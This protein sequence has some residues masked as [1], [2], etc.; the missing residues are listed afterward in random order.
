MSASAPRRT[1]DVIDRRVGVLFGVFVLLLL[2]A[3][4]RSGYLGLFRGSALRQA[5]NDQQVQTTP[6]PAVRGEITDRD[7]VVLALSEPADEII[8][9]PLLIDR[10]YKDPQA[11]AAQLA[12]LLGMTKVAAIAGMTKPGTGYVKLS[13]NVSA[14]D[15]TKIMALN[16][17]GISEVPTE[18]QAYPRGTEA[19]Q[20]IGWTGSGGGEG[21]EY[22]FN[23]QLEGVSGTR[24]SVIDAQG[25]AISIQTAKTMVPGKSLKLTISSPLQSE[26]EQVLAGVGQQYKP[27]GATAIVTDPQ[28]D[29]ILAL[30]N[31]PSV[32]PNSVP[33]SALAEVDGHVPAAEDQAVDM[34]YE[35]GS[36]FKAIT[37]AGA[38]QDG[39][40]TPYTTFDVPPYLES[41]GNKISDAEPHG[42]ETLSVGQILQVSSNIGADLIGQ[43]M[44]A[45]SFASWV[46][47]FG[48]GK[49][50]GVALPG[51]QRGI[52]LPE[53]Q[54][55][56]LSMFNLPFGQG[57]EVT[58]M[59]MVQAYD[60]IADGGVLRTP[61]II[62][63]IGSKKVTEPTG[64]R[65]ISAHV[66]SELRNML[67]GVLAD[68][69]TA[70]GAAIPGYD[71]AGK[72]GTANVVVKGKYSD[73]D[74]VASFIGMV[75]ASNPKLVIA[76][77]VN[78]PQGEIYGGSVAAPAF[79]KIVGWAVPHFGI[80]PCPSPCPASAYHPTMPST[81]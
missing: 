25:K 59:Q 68:G 24:R 26:V 37:V 73:S 30:A 72:T 15:A 40:V 42:Y 4:A 9:D 70:S 49:P 36:T 61:Q 50:T 12:P 77:V 27:Q 63:A 55:S 32:N 35:P 75:P 65:I 48:F 17:N 33:A 81:P 39:K 29:Q 20:L 22:L 47:R 13:G 46:D 8:A 60:A 11:K 10:T 44:G 57:E 34:S 79:Q 3:V 53:S 51:E 31:W 76:V 56:G 54:Y 2:V 74:Y 5:A 45:K 64:K 41:Y 19:G 62:D 52:V 21:L 66:A 14:T 1:V 6:I 67:R 43:K 18:H 16:V 58:P 7:G 71:L 80:N 28:T 23:R 69:G 78:A 38:L